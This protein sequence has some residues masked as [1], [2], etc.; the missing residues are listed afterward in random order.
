MNMEKNFICSFRRGLPVI[1]IIGAFVLGACGPDAVEGTD[2]IDETAFNV[3]A[4]QRP[5]FTEHFLPEEFAERREAI[6]DEIG[7]SAIAIL[8]GAA[9]PMGFIRFRQSNDFYY[10][11]GIETPH[12]YVILDGAERRTILYLPNRNERREYGEGK[13]LSAEDAELAV[14][15]SGV[16]E[17]HSTDILLD[18]LADRANSGAARTVYTPLAP[19]AGISTTRN[20][21]NRTI[22]DIQ[23][24]PLD[25]RASR[26]EH[27]RDRL[28]SALPGF[29]LEDLNPAIDRARTIKSPQELE[30][31]RASTRLH[32]LTIME[33]MRSTEPGVTEYE[34]EAVGKY[35]YAQHGAQGDAYYALA[36][37][38][39][40]A[41]M[42]HYHAGT[43]EASSG[44]MVLLDYGTDYHYYVSDMG[45]MWPANGRFNAVQ[46]ELYSFYLNFYE[47]ILYRIRPGVTAQQVKLE[48]LEEIDE[49]LVSTTFSEPHYQEA[50]EA[51]VEAYR[52]GAQD[53]DT[54]LGHGV[55]MA[56]H[57]PGD[58]TG[59]IR[60]GWVFVIEPQFRVPE[61]H[62]Y[63][64]LEDM[65]VITEDG[66]EIWTD[67]VPRDIEGIEELMREEG[68]LQRRPRMLTSSGSFVDEQMENADR[69]RF[70]SRTEHQ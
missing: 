30:L 53:P 57:D 13:M 10:L 34:L 54:R 28:R 56:A 42:N 55:G 1:A 40:N 51:F 32:G 9:S 7:E 58:Y 23:S 6:L 4:D 33:A 5:L 11:T 49:I 29:A 15:L 41:Y 2:R 60:P 64:R 50:A 61:E 38:G 14:E 25:G 37:I 24:D 16:D 8:Q 19:E 67:F 66:A 59:D 20:M 68:I 47:A 65:I 45:R 12:A 46:R 52:E 22:A 36:H 43:R 21:A 18:H 17:V 39:D 35:I 69:D 44:D 26:V 3:S 63:I 48:A 62:I 27:F 70:A 31:I